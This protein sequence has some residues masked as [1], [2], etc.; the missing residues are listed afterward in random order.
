MRIAI[1]TYQF[2]YNYGTV[3]QALALQHVLKIMGHEPI[4]VLYDCHAEQSRRERLFTLLKSPILFLSELYDLYNR[5]KLDYSFQKEDWFKSTIKT[6]FEYY[7]KHV[8]TTQNWYNILTIR[9]LEDFDCY[10]VGSD[11]TWSPKIN[12]VA[13]CF[14]LDKFDIH[15][16]RVA[17]APSMGA[18]KLSP[19]YKAYVKRKLKKFDSL[20]CRDINNSEILSKLLRKDVLNVVDPTLLLNTEEWREY[21]EI[22]KIEK[23]EKY[24]LYYSLGE[25]TDMVEYAKEIAQKSN[26]KLYTIVTRD[27]YRTLENPL[28]NINPGSFLWLVR[29]AQTVI[30]DSYHC[31]LF[32]INFH[33]IF[34]AFTKRANGGDNGRI[35]EVLRRTGLLDRMLISL[36][37]MIDVYSP[38]SYT[39]VDRELKSW[40]EESKVYLNSSLKNE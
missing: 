15:K 12:Q 29:N 23:S 19:F 17:Y 18:G 24:I 30:T 26:L 22:P 34:Y 39:K 40:I 11:Q 7:I 33:K 31:V 2:S 6:D 21:E 8:K 32:S 4:N 5:D 1:F 9:S 37:D 38:I 16:P 13:N 20:S 27:M 10:M 36:D 35:S 28:Y 25:R 14:F 3:L